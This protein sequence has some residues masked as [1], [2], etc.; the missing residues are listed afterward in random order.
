MLHRS[1]LIPELIRQLPDLNEETAHHT[2]IV[3]ADEN[4]LMPVLTSL[5]ENIGDINITMG[6]PL[7][8]SLVYTLMKHLMELA[9]K[10]ICNVLK[11][12]DLVTGMLSA[13]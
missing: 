10:C 3:L 5:P 7:K 4:L 11:Q 6:Y 1:K 13:S 2:A 9:E 8:H 12:S